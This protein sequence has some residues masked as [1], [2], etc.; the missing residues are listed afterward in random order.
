[1]TTMTTKEKKIQQQESLAAAAEDKAFAFG[2]LSTTSTARFPFKHLGGGITL[3]V[4]GAEVDV[5]VDPAVR[6]D[7]GGNRRSNMMMKVCHLL[8][9]LTRGTCMYSC[10]YA[11]AC[12]NR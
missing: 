1:M 10:L 4:S 3:G 2:L 8:Y 5:I 12:V 6:E 11:C 7:E 9:P